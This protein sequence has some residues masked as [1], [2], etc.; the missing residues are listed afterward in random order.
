[1]T[2]WEISSGLMTQL[3]YSSSFPNQFASLGDNLAKS[4]RNFFLLALLIPFT[5]GDP[6]EMK[7]ISFSLMMLKNEYLQE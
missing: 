3:M 7:M 4:K 5:S 1:M 6:I 2:K